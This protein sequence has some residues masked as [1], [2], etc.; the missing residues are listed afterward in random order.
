M[1]TFTEDCLS[2]CFR[3]DAGGQY[4]QRNPVCIL[5]VQ[6][7]SYLCLCAAVLL[8][9]PPD[10]TEKYIPVRTDLPCHVRPV[11]LSCASYAGCGSRIPLVHDGTVL[12]LSGYL[13]IVVLQNRIC[14]P[15]FLPAA[16]SN[17]VGVASWYMRFCMA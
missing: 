2:A 14:R 6:L 9:Q 13:L 7:Y 8:F 5:P 17:G 11:I 16:I 10:E 15:G 4:N 3:N 12:Y 1:T